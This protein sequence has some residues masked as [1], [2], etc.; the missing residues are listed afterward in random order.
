[1]EHT[2]KAEILR[3]G[4][5]IFVF[6]AVL[7]ALEFF[8]AVAIGALILLATVALVKVGLVLYYYMHI[9]RLNEEDVDRILTR[10]ISRLGQTAWDCGFSCSPTRLC[11]AAWRLRV[12][13]CSV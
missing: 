9:Y 1:M 5:M 8:I 3:Q 6:L 7:T 11:S 2:N 13:T 12:S 10:L 4:V